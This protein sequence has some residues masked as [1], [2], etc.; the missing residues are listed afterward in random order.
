MPS[1]KLSIIIPTIGR[2]SLGRTINSIRAALHDFEDEIIVVGDG[3]QLVARGIMSL[4]D[5]RFHYFEH[6]PTNQYGNA[7]RD[8]G[9]EKATGDFVWF[10]D[11]DDTISPESLTFIHAALNHNPEIPH[12]FRMKIGNEFFGPDPPRGGPIL[13]APRSTEFKWAGDKYAVDQDYIGNTLL[14][15][16]GEFERHNEV[17]Y[18]GEKYGRGQA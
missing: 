6:G 18:F 11:D 14:R 2:Q 3:P 15:H 8:F 9:V 5:W 7:Q 10:V 12:I 4:P 1:P 16:G 17:I 13:I